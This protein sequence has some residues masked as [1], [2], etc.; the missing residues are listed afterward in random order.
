[1]YLTLLTTLSG[2]FVQADAIRLPFRSQTFDAVI[3]NH[4]VEHFVNLKPALQEI[5]RVTKRDGAACV[6][7]PDATTFTDRLYRKVFRSRGGHVN[8][9]DSARDLEK[10]LTW[11][12]GLPHIA[13][14]ILYSSLGFL[15]RKN[16]RGPVNRKQMRFRGFPEPL[17]AVIVLG[18]QIFDSV[19]GT[20]NSI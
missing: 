12:L 5:G 16:T 2:L 20:R 17:L 15:N 6:T 4:S 19:V 11:Y 8:L 18:H 1:V 13:T 10:M 9:F 7:V 3:L 14:R